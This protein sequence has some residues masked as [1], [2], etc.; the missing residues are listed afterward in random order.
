ELSPANGASVAPTT[1]LTGLYSDA[2]SG[3]GGRIEFEVYRSSDNSLVA[4]G[5]GSEV[6]P[7]QQSSWSMPEGILERGIAYWWR[8]R[9]FDGT[10]PSGWT[11]S[12]AMTINRAPASTANLSPPAD[13]VAPD[14]TPTLAGLYADSDPNDQGRV[15][16]EVRRASDN[17][18]IASGSSALVA[19]DT[20][21]TWD[22]PAPSP[23]EPGVEYRWRARN[24]DEVEAS[25][26]STERSYIYNT[27]PPVPTGPNPVS[28]T[29]SV[30]LEPTLSAV[31]ADDDPGDEGRVEFELL[32]PDGTLLS[33]G[34]GL[35]VLPGERSEWTVPADLLSRGVTYQWRVRAF[36]GLARS[37]WTTEATY[38][39]NHSPLAPTDL[40]PS[41]GTI[42]ATAA[43][44]LSGRFEHSGGSSGRLQFEVWRQSDM[45]LVAAGSGSTTESGGESAWRVPP[46]L[47]ELGAQYSW[48]ARGAAGS[49][50]S[51]WTDA[52]F[53]TFDPDHSEGP[54]PP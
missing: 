39:T 9:S 8:A 20:D 29:S 44:V 30:E 4:S 31:Y 27:T 43:P 17:T 5:N 21:A 23:L 6:D 54:F 46:D 25:E 22:V 41:S 12:Q 33:S 36:D 32:N 1:N 38:I 48:R 37:P 19:P 28:A 49:T 50:V 26:W 14:S 18:L 53:Y 16:F 2:D 35:T 47:L 45:E 40:M 11:S 15:E 3:D 34:D 51:K 42:G 52:V 10:D 7:G 13:T 24:A